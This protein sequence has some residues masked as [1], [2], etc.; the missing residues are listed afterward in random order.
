MLA[1]G[2]VAELDILAYYIE[3]KHAKVKSVKLQLG[4]KYKKYSLF[5]FA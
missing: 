3:L 4:T 5:R 1:N 2:V